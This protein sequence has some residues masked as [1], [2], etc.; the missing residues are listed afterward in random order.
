MREQLYRMEEAIKAIAAQK[1]ITNVQMRTLLQSFGILEDDPFAEKKRE[2]LKVV[3]EQNI[4]L[5]R[6]LQEL[7]A[8]SSGAPERAA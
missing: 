8:R 2:M 6:Q 7:E 5:R 1:L 3:L 4:E